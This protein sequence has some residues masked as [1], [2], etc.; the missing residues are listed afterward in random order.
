MNRFFICA[1][2][3]SGDFLGAELSKSLLAKNPTLSLFG[4]GGKK[5]KEAGVDLLVNSD[6]LAVVGLLDSFKQIKKIKKAYETLKKFIQ[7]YSLDLI[8]LID[9]PGFNF[10]I[11][12]L[13][14]ANNIKVMYYASPQIWAWRYHRIHF[15][16]KHVDHMAVLYDF[17]EKMYQKENMPVTFVGHPLKDMAK[18]SLSRE[19]A[20]SYFQLNPDYPVIMLCAGSREGEIKNNLPV[21]IESIPIILKKSPKAQFV[22]PLADSLPK[23]L[24]QNYLQH[25][26]KIVKN[27]LYNLL[28]IADAAIATSGTVT[29]EIALNKVPLTVIYK[30]SPLSGWLAPKFVKVDHFSLCNIIAGKAVVKE[31]FQKAVTAENI[32][33]EMIE[34]IHNEEYRQKMMTEFSRLRENLGD[35]SSSKAAEVALRLME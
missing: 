19:Q 29:L 14:K 24:I 25:P 12:K 18:P 20:Y 33:R 32:G 6:E 22:L 30:M 15:I 35:D 2:E 16:K 13:A 1:G 27:D 9:Y 10:R 28:A 5:M 34:L 3:A 17:E 23:A 26:I 31:F 11:A 21:M 8:I 7:N 4:M